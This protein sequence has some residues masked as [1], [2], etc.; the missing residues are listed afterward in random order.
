MG[1]TRDTLKSLGRKAV[2]GDTLGNKG[3]E[4]RPHIPG[5]LGSHVNVQGRA[6][7][8]ER[9]EKALSSHL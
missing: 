8:S 5:K 4:K 1:Q 2:E 3:F 9:P 6:A 7:C